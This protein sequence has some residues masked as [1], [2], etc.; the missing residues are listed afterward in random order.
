MGRRILIVSDLHFTHKEQDEYFFDL[1]P[2]VSSLVE[3]NKIDE[4]FI[5]GDLTT[6]KEGHN[7]KLVNKIVGGIVSWAEQ[8]SRVRILCGN[9]D[10]V[11]YSSSPFF[12][13]LGEYP[14]I[15]FISKYTRDKELVFLPHSR[16][17]IS[18]WPSV[19]F[20]DD[21]Y[22]FAHVTVE[23]ATYESGVKA[24]EG[25]DSKYF[26]GAKFTFSGDI[27]SR[28]QVGPVIYVGSPYQLRMNDSFIGGGVIV[29]TSTNEWKYIDFTNFP[30]RGTIDTY[31]D[32]TFEQYISEY[33]KGDQV[34]VRLHLT[35]GNMGRWRELKEKIKEI[36]ADK[37]VILH[38]FE[39]VHEQ[40]EILP[41][42]QTV[43]RN[44]I[45]FDSYCESQKISQELQKIGI[46]IMEEVGICS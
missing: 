7:A 32:I 45:N 22:V 25:F 20:F 41:A 8:V 3:P 35:Q 37:G 4:I 9:H 40:N 28:Q 23:G 16:D 11:D 18:E 27:H 38:S 44:T 13:F 14:K 6:A 17:P 12:K 29:D 24:G 2:L 46:E 43:K 21:K 42:K 36:M 34:K 5:L 19:Q 10:L 1:F 15:E 30:K 33:K 26:R 31:S 39:M